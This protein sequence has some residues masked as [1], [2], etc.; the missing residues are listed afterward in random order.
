MMLRLALGAGVCS[1]HQQVHED[2]EQRGVVAMDRRHVGEGQTHLGDVGELSPGDA[3]RRLQH[4]RHPQGR[5]LAALDAGKHAHVAHD[6]RY[7]LRAF[8]GIGRGAARL[9][10]LGGDA[11]VTVLMIEHHVHAVAGVTDRILVLNFG[12]KIA[13]GPPHGVLADPA[14][15]S[16]YIGDEEAVS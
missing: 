4:V 9:R 15:I 11:G 8:E 5:E 6:R 2:L 14:V 13:E 10:E 16:A 7:A 12:E 1:V 3:H